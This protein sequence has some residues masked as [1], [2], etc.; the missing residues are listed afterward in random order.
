MYQSP[1][2]FMQFGKSSLEAALS[3]ANITLQSTERLVSL[4]MKTVKDALDESIKSAKALSDV[5]NVQDL[6]SLQSTTAQPSLE[7]AVAYSKSV[8]EV[9]A[10][11]QSQ[12]NKVMED[13]MAKVSGEIVA[14][15]DN[16]V[17]T[18]PAGSE[19]AVA[20]FKS[21]VAAANTAY[22]TLSK[23]SREAADMAM[24]NASAQAAKVVAAKKK[25]H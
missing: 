21:A 1:E 11:T 9:A 22:D 16:A 8:Y 13:R 15:I 18:A 7:K 4:Q 12:I 23:V 20:A 6:M 2:Q 25:A 17:K 5:K 14:A 3:L 24:N 19:A 10:D